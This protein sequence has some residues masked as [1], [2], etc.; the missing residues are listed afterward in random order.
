MKKKHHEYSFHFFN[1]GV[2]EHTTY[3]TEEV[4]MVQIKGAARQCQLTP[5][6]GLAIQDPSMLTEKKGKLLEAAKDEVYA[7]G[8]NFKKGHSRSKRF[9]SDSSSSSTPKRKNLNKEFREDRI[10]N[11]KEEIHDLNS[12]IC[13]K[14]KRVLAAANMKNYKICDEVNGEISE[15]K[16]KRRELETELKELQRKDN[17]AQKYRM[18][19]S[20]NRSSNPPS[21]DISSD[22]FSFESPSPSTSVSSH[23]PFGDPSSSNFEDDEPKTGESLDRNEGDSVVITIDNDDNCGIH[24]SPP[25]VDEHLEQHLPS[26]S[27]LSTQ[28]SLIP[29]GSNCSYTSDSP[30]CQ[31]SCQERK[32]VSHQNMSECG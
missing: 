2:S 22:E 20:K 25:I 7:C 14:E 15:L 13:F 30:S 5:T 32:L 19:R 29:T 4:L 8:Y 18:K 11:I 17:R 9:S 28:S 31:Q 23:D 24:N 1:Q 16:T 26:A 21:Q 10:H 27:R 3:V 12:R 6:L